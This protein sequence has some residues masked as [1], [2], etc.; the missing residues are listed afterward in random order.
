MLKLKKLGKH[1]L[2]EISNDRISNQHPVIVPKT[3]KHF[4]V[5]E[6]LMI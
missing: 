1:V 3:R 2:G 4:I 6:L 5:N